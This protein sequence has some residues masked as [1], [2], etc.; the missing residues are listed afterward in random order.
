MKKVA[1]IND[2]SGFG[3]CSLT[4]AIPV[5]SV[6]GIQACPLP[7]AVL[8]AQTGF[9]NYYCDDYTDRMDHFTG[10]WKEMGESFD[11]IYS[12]YLAGAS[13]VEKVLSFLEEFKKKDT[14]Y[15]ADPVLG[16]HGEGFHVFSKEL[17]QGMKE[18]V[19][20]ADVVTPNLTEL[21]F[22]TDKNYADVISHS[23][24]QD[25]V[26]RIQNICEE[27]LSKAETEQT[28][29]V[30]GIIQKKQDKEYVGNLVV[31]GKETSYLETPYTGRGFSGTGDLF[32]SVVCGAMMNG[33]SAGK[34]ME[35]AAYFLQAAIEDASEKNIPSNHGVHF[36]KY[37]SLLLQEN[38]E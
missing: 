20:R 2:L 33:L 1:L 8:T 5:I 28:V 36:E 24:E 35:K 7:T 6:M 34:A 21:C 23:D 9:E 17:L 30:T 15:L 4:A 13:Q 29:I 10:M 37:L 38:M 12:G 16:D 32:A 25:Y 18:L 3:K 31:S 14:M 22:L 11:G 19:L 27:L 26:K